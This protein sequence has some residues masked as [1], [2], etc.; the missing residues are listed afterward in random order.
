MMKPWPMDDEEEGNEGDDEMDDEDKEEDEDP[1]N[2]L[3]GNERETLIENTEAV[4]STLMKVCTFLSF[5]RFCAH[6]CCHYRFANSPSPLSIPPP[7]PFLHGVKPVPLT[8]YL[9]DLSLTMSKLDGILHTICLALLWSIAK[10]L[11][12][13][14]ETNP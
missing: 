10:L 8:L 1:L 13:L 14:Q 7:L 12:R 11:M 3:E 5:L 6:V 4:R 9:Y 2:T